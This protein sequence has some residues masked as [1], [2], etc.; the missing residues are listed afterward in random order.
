MDR[1]DGFALDLV[2]N[3]FAFTHVLNF[4]R[5][6]YLVRVGKAENL[7]SLPVD[8]DL[9]GETSVSDLLDIASVAFGVI[10]QC[11]FMVPLA[12]VF[13]KPLLAIWAAKGLNSK[14]QYLRTITPKKVLTNA[15][16]GYL[17]D[18]WSTQQMKEAVRAFRQS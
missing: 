17:I 14:T 9:T 6:W 15:K 4:F 3:V 7:Y 11:S 2:P 16:S 12:E 5:D 18:D 1:K 10:A 8:L 13:N